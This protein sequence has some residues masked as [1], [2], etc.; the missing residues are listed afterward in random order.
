MTEMTTREKKIMNWTWGNILNAALI[1]SAIG[2]GFAQFGQIKQT[3][4]QR[5]D[6]QK[7][8]D[9]DATALRAE[10]R[11]LVAEETLNRK[12]DIERVEKEISDSALRQTSTDAQIM[13]QLDE[14]TARL[15]RL[16]EMRHASDAPA[17]PESV[18]R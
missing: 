4:S 12:S 9:T 17:K 1:I 3:M 2:G 7:R 8:F 11:A 16:I 6:Q 18:V 10:A 14:I 5:Q 15:D 13:R